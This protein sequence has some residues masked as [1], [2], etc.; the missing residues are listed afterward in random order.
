MWSLWPDAAVDEVRFPIRSVDAAI[1]GLDYWLKSMRGEGGYTGPVVHWWENCW[2]FT[3]AMID[4]R[5]EGIICGYVELYRKSGDSYWL[6]RARRAAD[7]AVMSQTPDGH[8]GNS[9]F[10]YGAQTGGTPHEAAVDV[11]LLELAK[12]MRQRGVSGWERYAASA[13]RNIDSYLLARLWTG[14]GFADQPYNPVLVPNKNAT[15][16]EALLLSEE[17]SGRQVMDFVKP[18]AEV[19]LSN[20]VKTPGPRYG[21]TIHVGTGSHSLA[22]GIY[23]ARCVSALVRLAQRT[24]E[25]GY[26]EAAVMA[27]LFL[28]G[29][30]TSRGTQ[31]GYYLDERPIGAPEWISPSGDILRALILLSEEIEEARPA[32]RSLVEILVGS[33]YPTGGIPTAYGFAIRGSS[34]AWQGLP[35]F[36]DVVPVVGWCDKAFRALALL[37][38]GE[39][40]NRG[41]KQG[42]V[43]VEC[44]W[45]GARCRYSESSEE[46]MLVDS[47]S[48]RTLYR[49][50]KGE[51]SP[52]LCIL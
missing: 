41:D 28:A 35:E 30:V 21:A 33:Q 51:A 3:G 2:L 7:D 44:T 40:T 52:E 20:Q 24:G 38:D 26:H 39:V 23:T 11:G 1:S 48:G 8:F 32:A 36:R 45:R 50:R 5:Y 49:W 25:R 43:D 37:A 29:L 17:V 46:M 18:A 47:S 13:D 14:H 42:S 4:W 31:F 22:I 27:G 34:R 16:I 10:Q 19:V 6:A 12:A 9:S 15:A